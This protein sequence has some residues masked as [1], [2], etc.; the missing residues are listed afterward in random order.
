MSRITRAVVTKRVTLE[1]TFVFD[2]SDVTGAIVA[3]G[4]STADEVKDHLVQ[5]AE[6]LGEVHAD[7][8]RVVGQ[9]YSVKLVRS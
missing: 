8:T 7:E 2:Q 9:R 5:W 1:Y 3:S 4:A 6:D